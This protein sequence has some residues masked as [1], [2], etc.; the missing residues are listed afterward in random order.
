MS[1]AQEPVSAPLR[2][3]GASLLTLGRIRLELFAIEAQEEKERIAGLLL[4]AVFAALL[5]GFGLLLLVLLV[6]VA[7]W[8]SHRL[9]ALG[10]GTVALMAA[11][12]FA[13]LKVSRLIDQPASLFQSSI[14]ELRQDADALRRQPG[15]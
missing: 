10:G 3:L 7:L 8:D 1:D 9:L 2:R 6:T 15:P 4:W 13:V 5:A 11:A 14:G 12:V